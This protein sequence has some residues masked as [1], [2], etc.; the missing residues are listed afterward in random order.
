MISFPLAVFLLSHENFLGVNRTE[1]WINFP[2][3]PITDIRSTT[4]NT[5]HS[6]QKSREEFTS[7]PIASHRRP[8]ASSVLSYG[9]IPTNESPATTFFII[10]GWSRTTNTAKSSTQR[11]TRRRATISAYQSGTQVT[12]VKLRCRVTAVVNT[13]WCRTFS[14]LD[15][16]EMIPTLRPLSERILCDYKKEPFC[17]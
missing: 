3:F 11:A 9:V 10:H 15:S 1:Q 7:F 14:S 13:T 5:P 16:D 6:L 17:V 8:A 2:L 12:I 4:R